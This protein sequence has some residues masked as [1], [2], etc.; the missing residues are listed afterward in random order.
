MQRFQGKVAIVTGASSGIGKAIAL[1]LGGEGAWVGINYL[2]SSD[3]GAVADLISQIESRGGRAHGVRADMGIVAEVRGMF[4]EI[5]RR[6]GRLDI[7]VNNA[8]LAINAPLAETTEAQYQ[9][10]FNINVRGVLVACQ[11]AATRMSEGGRII[12]ISTSTTALMLPGYGIYDA[13][14]A[15]VEMMTRVLSK[16]IGKKGVTVNTISPGS[17]ETE[18]FRRGKSQELIDSFIKMS[19]FSRLGRPEDIADA[20]ALIASE[21]ARWITG[22]NIRVNGGTT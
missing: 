22:Q 12:N 14:K 11:E 16:E 4:E 21:E 5:S 17:T 6:F 13:S 7:L 2:S 10:V 20:V 9:E 1:K 8:A 15:A 3:S 19:S 18:Q